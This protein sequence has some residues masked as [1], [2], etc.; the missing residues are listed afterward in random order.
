MTDQPGGT[1]R[2]ALDPAGRWV[3]WFADPRRIGRGRWWREPFGGGVAEPVGPDGRPA[4]LALG[5]GRF[6]LGSFSGGTTRV[7][8]GGE[9]GADAGRGPVF[10]F[11]GDRQVEQLSADGTMLSVTDVGAGGPL[12]PDLRVL[13]PVSGE[14]LADWPLGGEGVARPLGFS[15]RP[16]DGRLLVLSEARDEHR[17]LLWDCRA[18]TVLELRH[19]LLGE[20]RAQWTPD[21][22]GLVVCRSWQGRDELYELPLDG[23]PRRIPHEPGEIRAAAARPDGVDYLW[24]SSERSARVRS[25]RH[26]TLYGGDLPDGAPVRDVWADGPGG[27]VHALLSGPPVERGGPVPPTVFLLHG[28]PAAFD[29][30]A[31][32]PYVSAWVDHGYQVVRTNYRGSTG[33]G[34][35]W[36]DAAA[37]DIGHAEVADLMA[38]RARLAADGLIDDTRAL[39]GGSSWG[40]CLALLA[41]GVH[42]DRWRAGF[43]VA[44]VADFAAAYEEETERLRALDRA[45]FGGTPDEVPD[46]YRRASPITWAPAVRAPVLLVAGARDPRCPPAQIEAYAREVERGGGPVELHHYDGG[47]EERRLADVVERISV[48]LEFALRHCPPGDEP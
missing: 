48:Q 29:A 45:L 39:V 13:D 15:P 35:A 44:P 3:W 28:G 30:D 12:R 42:P 38:V 8:T 20:L 46:R 16:S 31:Y 23:G 1:G 34:R 19:G 41:L 5:G 18:R 36:R 21:G 14:V 9:P 33:Y 37:G 43:A 10:D 47:H 40:G 27:R 2:Y 7:L 22:A 11:A 25:T 32:D 17:L 24:S 26:G 6:A 4:G